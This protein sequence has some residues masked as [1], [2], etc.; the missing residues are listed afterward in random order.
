MTLID[1]QLIR[2]HIKQECQ[3]YK[4]IFQASQK[5]VAIIRFEASEN[6]SNELRA[7]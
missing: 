4:S 7:R 2:E 6:T 1:G 3:K 5:E